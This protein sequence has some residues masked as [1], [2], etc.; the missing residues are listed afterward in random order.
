MCINLNLDLD[1]YLLYKG[2]FSGRHYLA[3]K[4]FNM[5]NT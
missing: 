5:F 3:F 2:D 1:K 4:S